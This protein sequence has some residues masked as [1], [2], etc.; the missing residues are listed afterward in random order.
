VRVAVMVEQ[1]L[2]RV[3][4]GTGRYAAEVAAALADD[5]PEGASVTAWTAW[6]RNVSAAR[7]PG[8]RGPRRLPL[9][10]RPL[11]AAWQAG[12]PLRPS[13]ADL[14]HAPTLLTPPRGR[15]AALVV[16][17]HDAV[18][19]THPETLTSRG[20]R[21]H[22]AMAARAAAE[23]DALVVPTSAVA[24]EL[25][26][27]LDIR[28][29]VVVA[30]AGVS[31]GLGRPADAAERRARLGLDGDYLVTV[32]TLEPRKGLD[33]LLRALAEA[34]RELP[35][36]AIVGPLGWGGVE[37]AA[38]A[39]DLGLADGRV[40]QLGRLPDDDLAAVLSGALVAV[41]P[42]RAE[43]FG[44]PAVEAMAAGVPVVTSDDPALVEVGGGATRVVPV[45]NAAA[46]GDT[47]VELVG[48]P[49]QRE[50][51]RAAGVGRASEYT[52]PAVAGRLWDLYRE[53]LGRRG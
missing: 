23:A 44:L 17:V 9:P 24:R 45:G 49:G 32:A 1:L 35:P 18:P 43:G 50:R 28:A 41:V 52:W 47:L 16:T 20:V 2:S 38:M 33:V 46:L 4:G 13:G 51:M 15:R 30:G 11:A 6:H 12:L 22:R 3:P 48:D 40:R 34:P 39:L 42:S 8:V 53:V 19:W 10:A 21:W 5:A 31:A 25:G 14:V 7:L 29:P 26:R 37:P 27:H 36:L